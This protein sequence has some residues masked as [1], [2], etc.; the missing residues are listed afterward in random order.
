MKK[1]IF[2]LV[3][4]F[5]MLLPIFAS[6]GVK[7]D[8][9][10][11][12]YITVY[13]T[14]NIYDFDPANNTYT[15]DTQNILTLLFE[16]LFRVNQ[17]GKVKPAL[18]KSYEVIEDAEKGEYYMDI[19]L[20]E[21][22]WSSQLRNVTSS[23]VVYA[24]KRLLA[25]G[26]N[27]ETAS[28]LFDIKNARAVNQGAS[29]DLLGVDPLEESKLRIH[30]ETAIDYDLFLL[31][32][33]AVATAPLF[34]SYVS[35]NPDWAKKSSTIACNGP[36]KIGKIIYK[37]AGG[38]VGDDNAV[39][40]DGTVTT[41]QS[42][43]KQIEYFYLERNPY[44]GRDPEKDDLDDAV[45][46]YR[47][48]V[49]CT[50]TPEEILN[51]YKEEKIFYVGN[52]PLSIRKDATVKENVEVSDALSTLVLSLNESNELF[53]N[54]KV[55][56]ALSLA[57]D[58]DAIVEEIVYA[59]AAT[60]LVPY[61]VFD[62]GTSGEFRTSKDAV[63]P[64]ASSANITSAKALLQEAGITPSAYSFKIKVAV[65]DDV[66]LQVASMVAESWNALGFSVTL[67]TVK[68]IENND[69]YKVVDD[70]PKDVCDDLFYEALQ[71]GNFDV[72]IY[73]MNAYTPDA[74]S[75]LAKFATGFSG[76]NAGAER[77]FAPLPSV[78]GYQST[79][80]D[81]LMEAVYFLPYFNEM[82]ADPDAKLFADSETNP[83]YG[84]GLETKEQYVSLYNRVKNVYVAYEI[85][86]AKKTSDL[87]KQRSLLL[88]K[89]EEVLLNDLPVI[90]VVFLQNAVLKSDLL[91]GVSK[92]S[93]SAVYDFRNAK[94][95]KYTEYSY[96]DTKGSDRS[97]FADF[98]NIDWDLVGKDL[99][100]DN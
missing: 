88:H 51:L 25:S 22:S 90:P 92:T 98:P 86:P 69:Y 78:T 54:E 29:E 55:R 49:D 17:K 59:K 35:N 23:D 87:K 66:Q 21:T 65:Y 40:K 42:S 50:K 10:L 61:A 28:L 5:L 75:V 45:L 20:K 63:N 43:A 76:R 62:Y 18:A 82:P 44:Y 7:N 48:L 13:L 2:S 52:I 37:D 68:P 14:D 70:T 97:I 11:G 91:S 30:F 6:C 33:T 57:I 36:F 84:W 24:W 56:K 4:C 95:K 53:A 100:K 9:D 72:A 83:Y 73:D 34:D 26:S 93:Y 74:Y 58:R 15:A 12:S 80:Y 85:V 94:L 81:D 99:S 47:L 32:L 96:V 39:E 46:P 27:Y 8:D 41:K 31:N 16:P 71:R 67:E 89:A 60:A 1:R 3:L 77:D 19:T 79:K 64:I 38:K